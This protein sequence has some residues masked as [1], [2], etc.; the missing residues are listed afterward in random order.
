MVE[1]KRITGEFLRQ[2]Q[3]TPDTRTMATAFYQQFA[4]EGDIS[5]HNDPIALAHVILD[6]LADSSP[7]AFPG[8]VKALHHLEVLQVA[9]FFV[10]SSD[11]SR[12]FVNTV[13]GLNASNFGPSVV[14]LEPQVDESRVQQLKV[15][16]ETHSPIDIA[17]FKAFVDLEVP[18]VDSSGRKLFP[19]V[20]RRMRRSAMTSFI[21][22]QQRVKQSEGKKVKINPFGRDVYKVGNDVL[23]TRTFPDGSV[24]NQHKPR[25]EALQTQG[26]LYQYYMTH[27][28]PNS[29]TEL[30]DYM[31]Q[32]AHASYELGSNTGV[33][34]LK[35]MHSL[36]RKLTESEVVALVYGVHD[37]RVDEATREKFVAIVEEC[38]RFG[39]DD[40][41][42]GY[43]LEKGMPVENAR[44]VN[45]GWFNDISLA[46]LF[47]LSINGVPVQD[48]RFLETFKELGLMLRVNGGGI[49]TIIRKHLWLK[50]GLSQQSLI[51]EPDK[52][53]MSVAKDA[54]AL[55]AAEE[56]AQGRPTK[57]EHFF[58]GAWFDLSHQVGFIVDDSIKR[59]RHYAKQLQ[60]SIPLPR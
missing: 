50:D 53:H 21:L 25:A 56:T 20:E 55:L 28:G 8:D 57:P 24:I 47:T 1:T 31:N 7:D 45:G 37:P 27:Y 16:D 40:D 51:S 46:R 19:N 17:I 33:F 35:R 52:K 4:E 13:R 54:A 42:R 22:E 6:E 10:A 32:S 12:K 44:L 2:Q 36:Q 30:I 5:R 9:M 39:K 60:K 14:H 11:G 58:D 3:L 23:V 43:T 34:T 29:P 15:I 26:D 41:L 18:K 49:P 38:R 59:A 48:P